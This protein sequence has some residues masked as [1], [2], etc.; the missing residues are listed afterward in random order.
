[1]HIENICIMIVVLP[2]LSSFISGFFG[3]KIGKKATHNIAIISVGISFLLSLILI[4]KFLFDGIPS[5]SFTLYEWMKINNNLSF[6]IGFLID[7]LTILMI[8]TVCFVS[9]MVHIYTVGYMEED[10]GYQ[11]F[12]C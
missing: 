3:N 4:K 11:R 6:E 5:T 12:F 9:W 2:L 8:S 10:P 1:M 7:R